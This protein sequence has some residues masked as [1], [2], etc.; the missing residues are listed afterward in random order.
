LS[1]SL[2][3]G[4][5]VAPCNY[6]EQKLATSS[7]SEESGKTVFSSQLGTSYRACHR[8]TNSPIESV[9]LLHQFDMISATFEAQAAA[10]LFLRTQRF[11]S[12]SCKEHLHATQNKFALFRGSRGRAGGSLWALI[13]ASRILAGETPVRKSSR[14]IL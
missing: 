9:A 11:V 7:W 4:Y 14:P 10:W 3:S 13:F 6:G 5:R 12:L 2:L 8:S 1:L